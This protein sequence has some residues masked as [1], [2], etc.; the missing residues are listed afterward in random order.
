LVGG[1]LAR[2]PGEAA[3][4]LL[5]IAAVARPTV[6]LV[7]VAHGDRERVLAALEAAAVEGVIE[8][9]DSHLR[10]AHSLLASI[11]YEQAPVW[12]RRAIHRVLAGA[13]ADIEERARHLGSPRR[14]PMPA[15][16][17]ASTARRTRPP[18]G[19]RRRRPRSCPSSRRL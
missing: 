11:C 4:V 6:E 14:A 13:A 16:Q 19:A 12:K 3:D 8:I 18:S 2:L 5:M 15:W 7:S 10:F 17:P 9:D 1:R